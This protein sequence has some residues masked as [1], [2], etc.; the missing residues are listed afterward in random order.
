[1]TRVGTEYNLIIA[2]RYLDEVNSSYSR[3]LEPLATGRRIN[4]PSDDP[5]R[6]SSY[7]QNVN[8][9]NQIEQYKVN[10][11]L[12]RTRLN[13]TD[14]VMS[15]VSGLVNEVYA[16]ALEGNDQTTSP[17]QLTYITDRLASIKE[18]L[19]SLTNTK[20]GSSYIFGGYLSDTQPFDFI[21]GTTTV[22]YN[23]DSNQLMV[24]VADEKRVQVTIDA[25]EAFLGGGSGVDIF[26]TIDELVTSIEAQDEIAIGTLITDIQSSQDQISTAR[27]T[28]GNS[29]RSLDSAE[30]YVENKEIQVSERISAV[31]DVD[32]AKATTDLS[33]NEYTLRSALEVTKRVLSLQLQNFWD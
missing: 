14:G 24:K 5:A 16:L 29:I 20:I 21:A 31:A 3:A 9:L 12:A 10:A 32:I 30:T 17:E 26:D 15:Q 27:A 33:F 13:I 11:S 2:R 18:D 28:I 8:E 22:T 4:R 1:M 25:D 19:M 7:F 23:G 6:I